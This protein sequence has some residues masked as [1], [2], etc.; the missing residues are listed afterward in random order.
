MAVG[1]KRKR[2]PLYLCF[3]FGKVT[4]MKKWTTKTVA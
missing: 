1:D 2:V 4:Q 3:S